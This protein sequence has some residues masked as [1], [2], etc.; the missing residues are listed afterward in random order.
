LRKSGL[1]L[2]ARAFPDHHVYRPDDLAFASAAPL[3]M[4]EKDAVKCQGFAAPDWWY[5]PVTACLPDGFGD[6]LL[7][8]LRTLPHGQEA[9]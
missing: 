4:T 3:L 1:R 8:Q 9:A 5:V 2:E 6:Q 7:S